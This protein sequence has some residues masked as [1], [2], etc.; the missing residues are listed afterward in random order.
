ML[1][2][3][4]RMPIYEYAC[5]NNHRFDLRQGFDADTVT[6]CPTCKTKARRIIRP[7]AVHYKGSGFYTTDYGRSSSYTSDVKK[8]NGSSSGSDTPKESKKE[9]ASA[10]ATSSA[11]PVPTA[12][13]TDK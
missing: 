6:V 8:E 9:S 10:P 7:P 3:G 1:V 4:E 2:L 13:K 5:T 11:P 12:G